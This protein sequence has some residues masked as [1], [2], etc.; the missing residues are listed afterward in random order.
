MLYFFEL[1][2]ILLKKF[3]IFIKVYDKRECHVK[4]Y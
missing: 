2:V 1:I 3:E 4:F